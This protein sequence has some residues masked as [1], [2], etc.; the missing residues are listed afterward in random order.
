[1]SDSQRLGI[2]ASPRGR[3]LRSLRAAAERL[4]IRVDCLAFDSL[5]VHGSAARPGRA[6]ARLAEDPAGAPQDLAQYQAILVRSMPLGSL[7]QTIF[8]MNALHVAS[9]AGVRVLN[10]PRSLEIAID[11]WLTLERA[12]AAG[13]AIPPTIVCQ[14]R[15]AAMDAW[16]TLGRD[17]VVKPLF[18]GEGR[19]LLRVEHR[20][21][22]ERVFSTLERL[23]AVLYVQAFIPHRGYDLRLLYVGDE[24]WA[25]A[26]HARGAEWRTNVSLGGQAQPIEPTAA[27]WEMADRAR[28]AVGAEIVGIDILPSLDGRDWLLEVNAVPGWAGTG[29]A[30][31]VDIAEKIVR[32]ALLPK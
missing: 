32:Y 6:W 27:Q 16:E 7:E 29:R 20:E 22:A 2:L 10:A 1:M 17:V 8:R 31:G 3:Y 11:K 21:M 18:G 23:Q 24:A 4:G 5:A 12:A 13:A 19:G 26:R 28:R 9:A 14:D 15:Q 30:V 25:V